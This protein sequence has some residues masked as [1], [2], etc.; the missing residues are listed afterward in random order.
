M[1]TNS[2]DIL[3]LRKLE[4]KERGKGFRK[5]DKLLKNPYILIAPA[6]ISALCFTVIPILFCFVISFC[7]WDILRGTL[8]F[9]G[10][11]NYK[12]IFRD[13]IFLKSLRNTI[14]FMLATVFGGLTLKILVGLAMNKNTRRH[15]LVQTVMFTPF[16]ISSVAIASVFMYLMRPG[17]GGLINQIIML[18]GGKPSLWYKGENTA[19]LSIIIISIWCSL[20]YGILIVIAGLKAIP[21]YVYEAARLDKSGK[22]N[23]LVHI[24]LP[25]LSPTVFYILVTSMTGAFTSF[26][27]VNIMTDGGPNNS[28]ELIALYIYKQGFAYMHYARAMAAAVVLFLVISSLTIINFKFGGKRIHYQ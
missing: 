16:I 2:E 17:D 11:K 3:V 19:L 28:T 12:F 27:T 20:G 14:V 24:T 8:T 18:F 10:L 15:N 7:N 6:I 21:T 1:L 26:D 9:A 13:E 22:L 25:L 4:L 23:T 5:F